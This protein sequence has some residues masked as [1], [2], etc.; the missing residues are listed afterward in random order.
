MVG[1]PSAH[2]AAAEIRRLLSVRQSEKL[3]FKQLSERSGIPPHVFAYRAAQDRRR[4]GAESVTESSGFV[5]VVAAASAGEAEGFDNSSGIELVF[6]GGL[7]ASLA[8]H[9]D[10][11]ALARLLSVA[12]C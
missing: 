6:P 3:T 12:G 1:M 4:A 8:R 7:R 10:D 11:T 2:H 5:E 9:F